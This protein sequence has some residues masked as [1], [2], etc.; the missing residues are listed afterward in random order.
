MDGYGVGEVVRRVKLDDLELALCE[1]QHESN[2][3][4]LEDPTKN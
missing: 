3:I 4:P 2:C 1:T